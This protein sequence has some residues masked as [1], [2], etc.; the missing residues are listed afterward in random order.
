MSVN[1]V[2][3]LGNCGKDPEVRYTGDGS[4]IA[5]VS[6]AT[7]SK[8]KDKN[9]GDVREDTEWHRV[10]CFGKIAEIVGEY[11]K[12]GSPVYFEGR[13]RTRKWQDKDGNDR[14]TTEIVAENVQL[15]GQRA[16][17]SGDGQ[18]QERQRQASTQRPAAPKREP[19]NG[20]AN[21]DGDVPF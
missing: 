6:V 17:Q 15:L 7:T 21:M 14:F 12:K 18:P 5:N 3:I 9:T 19:S 1:K 2:I 16:Q 11:V 20:T 8:W 10:S 4:A 13:L